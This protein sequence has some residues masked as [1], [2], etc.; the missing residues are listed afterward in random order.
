MEKHKSSTTKQPSDG[1]VT[2]GPSATRKLA[3]LATKI[4][5]KNLSTNAPSLGHRETTQQSHL[6]GD[7]STRPGIRSCTAQVQFHRTLGRFM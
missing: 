2:A 3:P 6:H 7:E 4:L 1:W 5:A